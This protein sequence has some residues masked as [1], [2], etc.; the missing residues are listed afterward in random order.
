MSQGPAA[1]A[2]RAHRWSRRA[3][4]GAGLATGGLWLLDEPAEARPGDPG[5][6]PLLPGR[7]FLGSA[8]PVI[9][10]AFEISPTPDPT[11]LYDVPALSAADARRLAPRRASVPGVT[12][13]SQSRAVSGV[14]FDFSYHPFEIR[15]LP[16]TI[17][18]YYLRNPMPLV[19]T[20]VHDASGVRMTV[21]YGRL[22]DHPVDQAQYGLA[23][24]ES[25]RIT[26]NVAYLNRA[27]KQA[28]RLIDRRVGYGGGWFYPYPF[29]F[30]LHGSQEIYDPPWYSMMAQGQ[31]LSL[32]CRLYRTTGGARWRNAANAT[33]ASF[34]VPPVAGRPWGVYV[35]GG[36]LWFEEYANPKRISG[37]LT[38]NG[39]NFAAFG[40]WDYWAMTGDERAR[41][42]LQGA[43][44][45][46]RDVYAD[47]R[48]RHW[49][50]K[51][52]LRHRSDANTYHTIHMTQHIQCYAI[53][54]DPVF[55][56]I[57]ELYYADF[58]PHGVTGTVALQPGRHTGYRFD[59]AG[60]VTA[61]RTISLSRRSNAPSAARLKVRRQDGIWYQISAG[62][63]A[64]YHL[65]ELRQ[66]SYQ[67]GEA[68]PMGYRILRPATVAVAPL[69]AYAIDAAGSMRSVVTDYQV[70]D[71][72]NLDRQ[73]VLNGVAHVRFA[74]GRYPG[75]WAGYPAVNRS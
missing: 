57:A 55:A 11:A 12:A 14:P 71:R 2:L 10:P 48:T 7:A 70:G 74:D 43:L 51:Y 27:K 46:M 1:E 58:P 8:G 75:W 47:I 20:G 24:V 35:V 5:A 33:F 28:Q 18:P 39:H 68:A 50:S 60:N 3:V 52:C 69:T 37:D 49:R 73:A 42:L 62:T 16:D 59:S 61:T 40:L 13:R 6:E 25:Y 32:F 23:L 66:H 17:R 21:R 44:T 36:R 34:L 65:K 67:V 63:L 15:D 56:Q 29:R 31:A 41:V 38:Y 4:L 53:T 22:Y 54:G 30:Q 19:D 72:V 26:G 64:G 9:D 45:T